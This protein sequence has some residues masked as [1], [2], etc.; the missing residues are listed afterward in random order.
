MRLLK[1]LEWI[2]QVV[3]VFS[4]A[5]GFYYWVIVL[6]TRIQV[7]KPIG[8]ISLV[9]VSF[10]VLCG[11]YYEIKERCS[12]KKQGEHAPQEGKWFLRQAEWTFPLVFVVVCIVGVIAFESMN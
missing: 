12:K 9:V 6:D 1:S 2:L 10:L 5:S 7:F 4:V 11:I 8:W 3:V